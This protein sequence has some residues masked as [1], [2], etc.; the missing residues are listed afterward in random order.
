MENYATSRSLKGHT[1]KHG[2]RLRLAGIAYKVGHSFL[3]NV[4]NHSGGSDNDRIFGIL[5]IKDKMNFCKRYYGYSPP[6]GEFPACRNEDYAALTRLAI[7]LMLL[8]EK[9]RKKKKKK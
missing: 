5:G 1:L 2:D 9:K 3:F 4:T 6:G 7:A 8:A